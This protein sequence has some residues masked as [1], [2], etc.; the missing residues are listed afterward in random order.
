MIDLEIILFNFLQ[1]KKADFRRPS[2]I[3]TLSA[4]RA[5]REEENGKESAVTNSCKSYI[6][7]GIPPPIPAI[8]AAAFPSSG[9]SAIT[10]SVVNNMAAIEAAF[11]TAI[12]VTF[13]GSMTPAL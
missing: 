1:Q 13:V 8:A 5:C 10:H 6:I 11:S 4:I 2:I 9:W 7:P 12:R 3:M